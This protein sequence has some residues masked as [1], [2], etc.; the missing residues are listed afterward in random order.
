MKQLDLKHYGYCEGDP[1]GMKLVDL[2]LADTR[3]SRISEAI[4]EEDL[5]KLH[6]AIC[7]CDIENLNLLVKTRPHL[8]IQAVGYELSEWGGTNCV[9]LES[10]RH[11]CGVNFSLEW[12]RE[13]VKGVK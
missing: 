8:I 9:L 1:V 13:V 4:A 3:A 6:S 7:H 5:N 12:V 10:I 11:H 2:G